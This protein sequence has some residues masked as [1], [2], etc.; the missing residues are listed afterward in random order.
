M[1]RWDFAD[2]EKQFVTDGKTLWIVHR[3]GVAAL[4][5]G[6][7]KRAEQVHEL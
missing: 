6:D 3:G 4:K 5:A 1:M 2:G 7:R